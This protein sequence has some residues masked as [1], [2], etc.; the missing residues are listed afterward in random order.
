[1]PIDPLTVPAAA[2]P[3][4][5]D[6]A[7]SLGAARVRSRR[8][9][10][11]IVGLW[12]FCLIAR[13]APGAGPAPARVRPGVGAGARA[14]RRRAA[15]AGRP[16]TRGS[17]SSSSGRSTRAARAASMPGGSA[18][19]RSSS[20][21]SGAMASSPG[22]SRPTASVA[23]IAKAHLRALYPGSRSRTRAVG[24]R[25]AAAVAIG[26]LDG[27]AGWP[28]RE[29]DGSRGARPPRASP[30][31]LEHAPAGAEVRLRCVARP[32][33]PD[34]LAA[35]RSAARRGRAPAVARP[36]R[37]GDRRRHPAPSDRRDPRPRRPLRRA[38]GGA[39][40]PGPQAPRRRRLRRRRS[41]SRSRAST[42]DE[43]PRRSCGASSTSR[44]ELDD[45]PQAIRW[46]DPA[47]APAVERP[48]RGSADWELA[49]LWSLPDASFDRAGFA[50]ARPLGAAPPVS[51][52]G[53]G[54]VARGEP[55]SRPCCCPADALAAPSRGVRLDGLG[56]EHAPAQ[57]RARTG[58]IADRGD[59]HRSPRRSDD[60]HP[61]AAARQR[62]HQSPRP[63]ARRP[64]PPARLQ[65]PRAPRRPTRPSS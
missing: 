54:L 60:R 11:A 18:G 43:A 27:P 4:I 39:R 41:R 55:R 21:S 14:P 9:L 5:V 38:A 6:S 57:P 24:D 52:D 33:P 3:M 8:S 65:L 50:R 53:L 2:R 51:P 25:P 10:A 30:R 32:V 62:G 7:R 56:Q 22:R 17:R 16:P 64:R 34:G 19:R 59:G 37:D 31:A 36:H 42:P 12:R 49:Q 47:V 26:R 61:G 29:V 46:A 45:G 15:G 58:G 23:A 63:A 44:R 20:G 1:M 48:R 35:R 13:R 28:L 40:G